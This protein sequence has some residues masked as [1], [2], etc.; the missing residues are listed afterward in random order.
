MKRGNC[1]RRS[2][3]RAELAFY[4]DLE[5]P[6]HPEVRLV[7]LSEN[8][9]R[10]VSGN[11]FE[12]G[13]TF[14]GKVCKESDSGDKDC[15]MMEFLVAWCREADRPGYSELGCRLLDGKPEHRAMMLHLIEQFSM[16]SY[17]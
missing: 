7:D 9:A 14:T 10:L 6:D 16:H 13:S 17:D 3:E 12:V 5:V 1:E 15:L 2:S 11:E 4:V 8:G